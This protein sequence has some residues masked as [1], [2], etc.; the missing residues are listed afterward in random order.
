[1]KRGH[2][3]GSEGL[4]GFWRWSFEREECDVDH[5]LGFGSD[6]VWIRNNPIT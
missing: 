1:M 2:G 4:L 3:G 6:L 5:G